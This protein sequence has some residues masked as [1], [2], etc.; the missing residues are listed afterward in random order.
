MSCY[1]GFE[2]YIPSGEGAFENI[3]SQYKD[4]YTCGRYEANDIWNRNWHTDAEGKE[5]YY[6][7][8]QSFDKHTNRELH[9][10]GDVIYDYKSIDDFEKEAQ[11]LFDHYTEEHMEGRKR[12]LVRFKELEADIKDYK[13]RQLKIAATDPKLFKLFFESFEDKIEEAREALA[14]LK[15]ALS[16]Y[17]DDDDNYRKMREYRDM[18]AEIRKVFHDHPNAVIVQFCES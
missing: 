13:D 14:E 4:T 15:N 9:E 12:L 8:T 5:H 11:P 18:I 16:S 10:G 7:F 6:T 3:T 1:N 17:D 2:V